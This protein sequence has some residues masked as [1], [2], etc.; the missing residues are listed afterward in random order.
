MSTLRVPGAQLYYEV[1]GDGPLLILI[2]GA[3]GEGEVFHQ[4]V[5]PLAARYEVVTYD[6]RGFSRSQLDGPQDDDRR[7][8]TDVDDVRCL[9]EHITDKPAIVFGN[10]SGAIVALEI[11]I[12][13]PEL[14]NTVV[15]HEPPVVN[16]LPDASK[17]QA[18]FDE[19]YDTYC[20]AGATKAMHQFAT[21][22][23]GTA[24]R[25]LMARYMQ[26]HTN[27]RNLANVTYWLEHE[28]R[29]Y[30]RVKLDL[31]GL[32]A[33]TKQLVLAG[34]RD[35][36]DQLT[37]LPNKVLAQKLGLEMVHLSGGHLGFIAN[38]VEFAKELMDT[39]HD[40]APISS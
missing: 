29:Q 6:R 15:A 19:V 21:G 13:H 33:H 16:L 40:R 28:L 24:D 10:S 14:I 32:A 20:Q 9:I 23:V 5:G 17:W 12:R 27:E 3:A 37:Y 36:Q 34:G 11:L 8:D 25:Q 35:S 31:D 18:F 2:P 26:L 22:T 1:S 7:L 39:L 38:P 4:L 30:P